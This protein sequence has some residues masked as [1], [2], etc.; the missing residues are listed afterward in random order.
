MDRA[1]RHG[2]FCHTTSDRGGLLNKDTCAHKPRNVRS[3]YQEVTGLNF[4]MAAV[5]A[6]RD[7]LIL[8]LIEM[9]NESAPIFNT[10]HSPSPAGRSKHFG[11]QPFQG[12]RLRRK[13][14]NG[15]LAGCGV[16]AGCQLLV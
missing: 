8:V 15:V 7:G 11:L 10:A 4:R 5:L 3:T 9:L 1:I 12:P 16:K 2:K 14:Y 6:F 13:S